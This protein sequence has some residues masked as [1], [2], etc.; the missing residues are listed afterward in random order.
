MADRYDIA[1]VGGGPG[2]YSAAIRAA[3]L[4]FRVALVERERLGGICGNWGCIP[5]KAIISSTS[6]YDRVRR[7]ESIGLRGEGV[8]FDYARIVE[9]SR[10]AADRVSRGVASLMKKNRVAVVSGEGRLDPDGRLRIRSGAEESVLEADRVL[11]AAGSGERLLPGLRLDPPRVVTSRE[12]LEEKTLPRSVIIIGGGVIGVE[13]GYV[14]ACLGV[15]VTIVEL[16]E[17]LLPGVEPE[18]ARELERS[19]SRRGVDV[20]TGCGFVG[21]AV[22]DVGVRV[23]ARAGDAAVSLEAERCL[24]AVG[25]VART[26]ELG[27]R[28]AGVAVESGFVAVNERFETSLPHVLAI[29]DLIASPQLAHVAAAEGVAAMEMLADVRVP[30]ALDYE[31]IPACVYCHPEVATV[32]ITEAEARRRGHDVRT[33]IVPFKALG[34]AVA[35]GETEGILKLVTEAR[36]GEILGCHV[37][38]PDAT[39]LIAEAA[40]AMN[41]EATT[42]ELGAVVHAHPTFSEALM[43]AALLARGEAINL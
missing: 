28:E 17:Q 11:L 1:V 12:L 30:G 31:R 13:F 36:H 37:V 16:K 33:A 43:E 21:L 34:R 24:V 42:A 27:L 2:G 32:G 4:G 35:G 26:G 18:V 5:Y 14:F 6:I 25:R 7:G 38:G 8:G 29:G 41:L 19:F 40:L 39:E 23:E 10:A 15:K 9:N 3:Q 20:R 22:G